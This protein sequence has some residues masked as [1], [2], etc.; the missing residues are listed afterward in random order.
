MTR[1]FKR[2]TF[3]GVRECVPGEDSLRGKTCPTCRWNYHTSWILDRIKKEKRKS[4]K[5]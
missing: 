4:A 1:E 3:R 5:R 2:H